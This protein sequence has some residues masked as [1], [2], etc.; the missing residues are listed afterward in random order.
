MGLQVLEASSS[1]M[2]AQIY[3][4]P[5]TDAAKLD[6]QFFFEDRNEW[7]LTLTIQKNGEITKIITSVFAQ[8]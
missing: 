1:A 4:I 7:L 5:S 8:R 6:G 3:F 2:L